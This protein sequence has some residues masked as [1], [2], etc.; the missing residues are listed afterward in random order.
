VD[1]QSKQVSTPEKSYRRIVVQFSRHGA[2]APTTIL[3]ADEF[4]EDKSKAFKKPKE[5]TKFGLF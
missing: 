5:L 4:A 3:Y 2:R 1:L